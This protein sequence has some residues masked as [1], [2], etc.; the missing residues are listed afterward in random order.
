MR[1]M[2]DPYSS[3]TRLCVKCFDRSSYGDLKSSRAPLE[4]VGVRVPLKGVG[5]PVELEYNRF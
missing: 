1:V 4:G 3:A 5:V 2:W